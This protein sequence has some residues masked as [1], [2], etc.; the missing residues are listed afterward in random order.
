MPM[1]VA[2]IRAM[3][4]SYAP[5]HGKSTAKK[6]KKQRTTMPTVIRGARAGF[7]PDKA[8]NRDVW[9]HRDLAR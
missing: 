9:S 1:T 5:V 8:S 2:Q 7:T 3:A 4:A 6:G